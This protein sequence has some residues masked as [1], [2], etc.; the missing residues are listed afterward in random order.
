MYAIYKK[1]SDGGSHRIS[2]KL[3]LTY[4]EARNYAR[5]LL[6]KNRQR[7][8]NWYFDFSDKDHSNPSLS[9][10]NYTIKFVPNS[11]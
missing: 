9:Q 4:D 1:K 6:R 5:K 11:F 3:F 10:Y 8:L 7:T 2:N